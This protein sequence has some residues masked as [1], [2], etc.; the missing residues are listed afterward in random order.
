MVISGRL[1]L[2]I[3]GFGFFRLGV[4]LLGQGIIG[5]GVIGDDFWLFWLVGIDKRYYD[6]GAADHDGNRANAK[7]D[8]GGEAGAFDGG[9]NRSKIDHNM[10]IRFFP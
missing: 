2:L 3:F 8:F 1:G 7:A 4:F 5:V 10:I 9:E 6:G